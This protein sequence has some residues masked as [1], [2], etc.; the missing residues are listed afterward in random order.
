MQH[1]VSRAAFTSGPLSVKATRDLELQ[2]EPDRESGCMP[3]LRGAPALV[4]VAEDHE[5]TRCALTQL[6]RS[7]G[8]DV[9]E[10]ANGA[11]ALEL[12]AGAADGLG[13]VP[14]VALLDFLMPRL[15]GLGVLRVLRRFRNVPSAII[16]TAFPDPS[17]ET[18]ARNLGALR[19]LHKP[20]TAD[21]VSAS[22]LEA[23]LLTRSRSEAHRA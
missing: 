6:L 4:L 8:Y 12:I 9:M 7:E 15:S 1:E 19:V 17:V 21:D 13:P 18:F 11:Q 16:M 5:E 20:V 3:R 2:R 23:A 22:V 14:D 10:A